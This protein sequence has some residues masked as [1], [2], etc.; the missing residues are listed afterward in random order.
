MGKFKSFRL[1]FL[2]TF[3]FLFIVSGVLYAQ[4]AD[5]VIDKTVNNLTWRSI[6]PANMA[7]RIDDFAVVESNPFIVY[8]GTASGGIW[9]TTNNGVTWKPIFD[10]QITS[11]IGNIDVAPSNP[12]VLWVG[13]GEA[14]NRQSS[15]WGNGVYKSTDGGN[16]WH[17]MGLENTHHIGRVRI[18]P[19]NPDVVYIAATGHLWGSN[20]ERGVYK[21]T[22]GGKTW[23]KVLYVNENTGC[24]DLAIDHENN[25]IVYAAMYQRQ[26]K[27][28]GFIGGGPGSGLYKTVDAG[29]TWK[30]LGE[31]LPKG[32]AGRIG[33]DIFRS[34][35]NIVYAVYEHREGGIFRSEDKGETWTKMSDTNPRPMYYSKIR[36]DPNN[37]QRLWVLGASMYTSYDGGKTFNTRVVQRIHS[38]HHAMWI[39]PS[40]SNHMIVG[41]DGG[42]YF[43]YDKG[44]TWD[45][46]CTI[47]LGQ[48]YEVGFDMQK[49]YN[50]YGGLQDNGSWGGPSKTKYSDGITNAD[51]FRVGGGDGFYTQI[52]PNDPNIL[53]VESQN[54]SLSRMNL[55]TKET[56]SIRPT[57]DDPKERYRFNWNSPVFISPHNSKTIYYGGNKLFKSTNMGDSWTASIDLTT[58]QDREKLPIMGILPDSLT[59]SRH[60]GISY[61]GDIITISESPITEGILWVGTDDGN[62]QL[63]KDGGQTWENL[64]KK[65]KD[66]PEYTYVSR[67]VASGHVESRAY[68]TLD[69][70]RNDDFKPYVF[71][72]E[73]FGK[74]WKNISKGIPVGST[75]NVI[76]E[77]HKNPNILFI[78]TERGA[79]FSIDRGET[80][81]MF[82]GNLPR[83]PVDDIAIHPSENDLIFGTHGR[84]IW[85][86]DDITPLEQLTKEV[87]ESDSYLFS[88]RP[89]E[90]YQIYNRSGSTGH[91]L[92]IG[93]NPP[94]GAIIT[95][96]LKNEL[97]RRDRLS[98]TV[99]DKDGKQV[100]RL[101]GT[102][103]KGFNRVTW[104]L[105]YQS[106][107]QMPEGTMAQAFR[108]FAP[109]GPY[110]IPGEYTIKLNAGGAEMSTMV[111]V[112][113]DP[114]YDVS[115]ADLIAQRDAGLRLDEFYGR[116]SRMNI[117]LRTVIAQ[118]SSLTEYLKTSAN[119]RGEIKTAVDEFKAKVDEVN[120]K[121]N[122]SRRRRDVTAVSREIMSV[123]RNITRYTARPTEKDMQQIEKI[124][125]MIEEVQGMFD[126]LINTEVPAFNKKLSE[127][128][129]PLINPNAPPQ[130]RTMQ[131]RRF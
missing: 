94:Y 63:S 91:K 75:V 19:K 66:V 118:L 56:K 126:N 90:R 99:Y 119:L 27:G 113:M 109:S 38:D 29:K 44:H 16:T 131:R 88:V 82:K 2:L 120:L 17:H 36:I 52:D 72:T 9:K 92:F 117:K 41:S 14:N 78:G 62:V 125:A 55:L 123:S 103:N 64:I 74:K 26:R 13:T 50:I 77:H 11:T 18:D 35:P 101:R 86:L 122:G 59:L 124:P 37:D 114:R 102:K 130:R 97:G 73:D 81:Y 46:I 23:E 95:Y 67:V 111:A 65:I 8:V 83:V 6:G 33:I 96:Y 58:Q 12:G 45:Y 10:D 31:G 87:L 84:S 104:N 1:I 20:E 107:A 48:F 32:D 110:V 116:V 43:S 129:L 15:S 76:R 112:D 89:A 22:D 4:S 105:R 70:H 85:V 60:D 39:N 106:S 53:Y 3:S 21:T 5:D 51:W 79:Y 127:L 54:G 24:I 28:Y 34:D 30:K 7:G 128:S 42:I 69:G 108:R 40:N 68:V 98:V 57:P 71:V 115:E 25:N 100:R 121:L 47:P 49:P 80:W 61:Y 93:P